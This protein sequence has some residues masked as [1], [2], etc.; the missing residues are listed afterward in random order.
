MKPKDL[1]HA[2]NDVDPKLLDESIRG[3]ESADGIEMK[4]E[5]TVTE[6]RE[7]PILRIVGTA[8][9]LVACAAIV[10]GGVLWLMHAS[11]QK[12][13]V[14]GNSVTETERATEPTGTETDTTVQTH[15]RQTEP[16]G[17][18]I[19]LVTWTDERRSE[20]MMTKTEYALGTGTTTTSDYVFMTVTST[21]NLPLKTSVR[22]ETTHTTATTA[23]VTETAPGEDIPGTR[24][25]PCAVTPKIWHST[26]YSDADWENGRPSPSAMIIRSNRQMEERNAVDA[27]TYVYEQCDWATDK[28]FEDYDLIVCALSSGTGSIEVG[29]QRLTLL[30]CTHPAEGFSR[31]VELGL[32]QYIPQISTCDMAT[33]CIAIPVPK[34]LLPDD[35][36]NVYTSVDHYDSHF[37]ADGN[38]IPDLYERYQASIHETV[39][40][41]QADALLD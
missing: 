12:P 2:M 27:R 14:A 30:N 1:L 40:L 18:E 38:M 11:A 9:S 37:D 13:Q 10:T 33:V 29:V 21:S 41:D 3:A 7:S 5:H 23:Q 17:T 39:M 34:G 31:N 25:F 19:T 35:V 32:A 8:A 15:E 20:P 26:W 24:R 16:T 4:A 22:K 6:E 28:F 36:Q